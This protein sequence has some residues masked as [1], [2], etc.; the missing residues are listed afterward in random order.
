MTTRSTRS[1]TAPI[2]APKP[3]PKPKPKRSPGGTGLR[4]VS[5]PKP[6]ERRV[7]CHAGQAIRIKS[8]NDVFTGRPMIELGGNFPGDTSFGMT[9]STARSLI[10]ALSAALAHCQRAR[11]AARQ[12]PRSSPS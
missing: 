2:P 7:A 6:F 11:D 1:T 4:P 8:M 3:A 5:P 10:A 9:P 12:R